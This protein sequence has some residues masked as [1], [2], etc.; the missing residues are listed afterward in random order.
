[1]LQSAS[2]VLVEGISDK[3]CVAVACGWGHSIALTAQGEAFSW[4]MGEY[5]ALGNGHTRTLWSPKI[6]PGRTRFKRISCGSRHSGLITEDD[7]VV[8]CG[9]GEA[10]QLGTGL[11]RKE[12]ELVKLSIDEQRI[13]DVQCGI[14]HTLFLTTAGLVYGSGG[15][16]FG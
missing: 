13:S 10:G 3:R 14:F 9:A 4:G 15:N 1:M 5:G 2:P 12:V 8:M 6:I 16:T 7:E 11:R